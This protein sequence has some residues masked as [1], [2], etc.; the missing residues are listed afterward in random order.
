MLD[1]SVLAV[2]TRLV[3]GLVTP[4]VGRA[5]YRRLVALLGRFLSLSSVVETSRRYAVVLVAIVLALT[6]GG[7]FFVSQGISIDTDINKLI[8]PNLP[9]RLQEQRLERAFP[10]TV[11][12]LA[13]LVEAQTPDE[14]EDATEALAAKLAAKKDL[15]KSVRRPDGGNFFRMCR[16]SPTRSSPPS[17]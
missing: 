11:D 10:Q 4:L 5:C 8:N 7:G 6:V 15:F 16:T 12:V 9:W 14:T 3:S 13:V 17:R 2:A 1:R